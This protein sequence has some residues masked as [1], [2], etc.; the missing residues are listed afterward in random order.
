MA[1]IL[2]LI[3]HSGAVAACGLAAGMPLSTTVAPFIL[4][5]VTLAG[6]DSV[7][8]PLTRRLE[9]YSK[10]GPLLASCGKL[11]M[12]AGTDKEVGLDAVL[13]LS[14]EMLKGNITGRYVV[15]VSK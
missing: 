9:V 13:D 1:N 3:K 8:M 15:D 11:N 2:P 10:Y 7:F 6:V 5:G 12:L 14:K 4:R